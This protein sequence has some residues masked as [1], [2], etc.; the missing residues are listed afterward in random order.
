MSTWKEGGHGTGDRQKR[1]LLFHRPP[2][3][4]A[5][6]G[7]GREPPGLPVPEKQDQ[8]DSGGAVF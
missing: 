2:A 4:E 3:G 6:L 1:H 7:P 8:G 5:A